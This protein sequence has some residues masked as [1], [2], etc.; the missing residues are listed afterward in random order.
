M[1]LLVDAELN[2]ALR[3]ADPI[4]RGLPQP[5]DN[6]LLRTSQ[7][8]PASLTLTIGDIFL[9]GTKPEDLGGC[10]NPLSIYELK[11]GH[12]AVIRTR[13]TIHLSARQAA[14]GFPPSNDSLNGML[15]TNPGHIDPGYNGPLH[16]TVI[17]MA[18]A[19][20]HLEKGAR[21]MRVL[22]FESSE[23]EP[24]SVAPYF[25]RVG[26]GPRDIGQSPITEQLLCRLST[27]FVDVERRSEEVAKKE[28][29][30]AQMWSLWVPLGVAVVAAVAS[31]AGTY[32]TSVLA[33]RNDL[34]ALRL[35]F[36]RAKAG[37]D[38]KDR[39]SKINAELDALKVQIRDVQ[40]TSRGG[41][42]R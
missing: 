40:Q 33:V 6:G 16:C 35:D 29:H 26:I 31:F 19:S 13:E 10:E 3:D 21:I 4:A 7:V 28:V 42:G 11:Q 14:I 23:P 22:I 8:R 32:F 2:A 24:E 9:P 38:N 12:T 17:N 25:A 5:L 15:M 41:Q 20:L 18:H 37:L 1:R 30:K 36:E 34:A 27:D 39:I